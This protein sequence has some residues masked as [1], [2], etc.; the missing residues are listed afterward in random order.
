MAGKEQEDRRLPSHNFATDSASNDHL[1]ANLR[2]SP[3]SPLPLPSSVFWSLSLRSGNGCPAEGPQAWPNHTAPGG[4]GESLPSSGQVAGKGA[5]PCPLT[6]PHHSQPP[7]AAA[8]CL[9]FRG[10]AAGLGAAGARARFCGVQ[11]GAVEGRLCTGDRKTGTQ[12][13]WHYYPAVWLEQSRPPQ[14]SDFSIHNVT[15]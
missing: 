9:V 12:C 11:Q 2:L 10:P 13:Q 14:I 15:E 1:G 5:R 6:P 7:T 3:A 4:Q 8:R